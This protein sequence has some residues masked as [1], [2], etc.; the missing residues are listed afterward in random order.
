[1]D[2]REVQDQLIEF[3][4]DQLDRRDAEQIRGHLEICSL[5]R[6]ELSSIERVILGLKSQPLSDPGEVFWRDFPKK[7]REAFYEGG[8]SVRVPILLR[9]REGFYRTTNW[10]PFSKAVN[11]AVSIAA[12]VLVVAGL[13]FFRAGWFWMGSAGIGEEALEGYFGGAEVVVSPFVPGSLEDLSSYQLEDISTSLVGWLSGMG[14]GCKGERIPGG[15][16]RLRPAGGTQFRG[17][18]LC[19]RH[20]YDILRRRYLKSTTF[21]PIPIG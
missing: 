5:C 4:E 16:R 6:E 7:V 3:Y 8:R 13:L 17:T 2:C 11:A 20:T 21:F 1:M 15:R 10:L 19:V 14:S 18:G 12:M 9:V